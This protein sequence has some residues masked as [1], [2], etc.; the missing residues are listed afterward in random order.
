[1]K[2]AMF[3]VVLLSAGLCCAEEPI[4][5]RKA[6]L[7]QPLS[8]YADCSSGKAKSLLAGYRTHGK[9]CQG[10]HGFVFHTKVS[11]LWNPRESGERLEFEDRTLYKITIY[12][13]NDDWAKVRYDLSEKLGEPLSEVPQTYQNLLG[14]RWE[15]NQGFWRK[16]NV[17]A[18]AG[19]KVD[20]IAPCG[21]ISALAKPQGVP[22]SD[23]IRIIITTPERAGEPDTKPNSLD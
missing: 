22:C 8:D 16:G 14:A 18:Y 3:T 2:K 19:M 15:F 4:R 7:G 23:N 12:V 9:L 1:M 5:F 10:K 6:Y 13:P 17:V 11:G 20:T 21:G